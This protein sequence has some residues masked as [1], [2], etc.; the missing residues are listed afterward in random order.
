M[1]SDQ[2][3]ELVYFDGSVIMIID[4]NTGNL[5]W[6]S[7]TNLNYVV[8]AGYHK[9]NNDP[10]GN[11]GYSPFCDINGDGIFEITVYAQEV[12]GG[13]FQSYIIGFAGS[14]GVQGNYIV[15][16][17]PSLSQNYPN[18]FNPT[19][20]IEYEIQSAGNIEIKIFDELGQ[21]IRTLVNENKDVG[22]Y[23]VLWD[24]KNDG[25]SQVSTGAYF[26]QLKVNDFVSTKKMILLK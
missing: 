26:Y 16:K 23:S 15:P 13:P 18:P 9:E 7:T 5:E 6:E 14:S 19:T 2:N 20:T 4:G 12:I 11:N 3:E 24:G 21:G 1:D 17:N 22:S 8:V 10:Y 25:G